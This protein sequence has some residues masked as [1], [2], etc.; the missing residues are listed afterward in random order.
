MKTPSYEVIFKKSALKD[1]QSFPTRI[2]K[3][4]LEAVQILAI[5]PYSELLQIKKLKGSDQLY[6]VRIQDY[7]VLYTVEDRVLK[8]TIIKAAHRKEAYD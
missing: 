8:I 5:N 7:R 4:I 2:Q 1:L 3:K 6:R